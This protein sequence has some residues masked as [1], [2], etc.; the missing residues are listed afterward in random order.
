MAMYFDGD[1][2]IRTDKMAGISWPITTFSV[3]TW[4]RFES[5]LFK[6][7]AFIG[8]YVD[9]NATGFYMRYEG[10]SPRYFRIFV[11]GQPTINSDS[12]SADTNWHHIAFC[13]GS[14]YNWYL[15]GEDFGS[16][17][18]ISNVLEPSIKAFVLGCK[19]RSFIEE[20]HL[21]GDLCESRFWFGVKRTK[22]QIQSNMYRRILPQTNL[23]FLYRLDEGTPNLGPGG[24]TAV[25]LS[26]NGNHGH[27]ISNAWYVDGPPIQWNQ[28]D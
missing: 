25:D 15:D 10:G 18:Q 17:A 12:W 13:T 4:I 7:S 6:N 24:Y 8:T 23:E 11:S 2:W 20:Q 14:G 26:G 16:G 28:G 5:P 27:E 22:V 21:T 19:Y 1:D 3:E 9:S